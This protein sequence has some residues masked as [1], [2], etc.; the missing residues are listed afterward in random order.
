MPMSPPSSRVI[1]I[2]ADRGRVDPPPGQWAAERTGAE[3]WHRVFAG[4]LH[5]NEYG[6]AARRLGD[7]G[8]LA[9][10]GSDKEAALGAVVADSP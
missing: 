6:L 1:T 5:V 4:V 8:D 9:F 3:V 7:A 10:A 2:V